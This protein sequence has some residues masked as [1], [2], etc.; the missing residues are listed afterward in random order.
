MK[1]SVRLSSLFA[2]D[3]SSAS[4]V[5]SCPKGPLQNGQGWISIVY[6]ATPLFHPLFSWK[7]RRAPCNV[8]YLSQECFFISAQIRRS[9]HSVS[10]QMLRT[11]VT[12]LLE[13]IHTHTLLTHE[14]TS[15]LTTSQLRGHT[16]AQTTP[17]CERE[18]AADW[19]I[20]EKAKIAACPNH[21]ERDRAG[22]R[23]TEGVG[24]GEKERRRWKEQEIHLIQLSCRVEKF[25][26]CVQH[27]R[28]N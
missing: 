18:C 19:I 20:Q 21:Q 14:H 15:S 27:C 12:M 23:G 25:L 26:V 6:S 28:D 5:Q 7:K 4:G 3:S 11:K 8:V 13:Q 9:T 17:Y 1:S 22:H 16:S 2:K 10:R 24:E